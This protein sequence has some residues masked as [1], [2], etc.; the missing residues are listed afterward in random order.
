MILSVLWWFVPQ[1]ALTRQEKFGGL[2]FT[3]AVFV[4]CHYET[5]WL[6][7]QFTLSILSSPEHLL[8]VINTVVQEDCK[9]AKQC[10]Q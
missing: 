9:E 6:A 1:I 10:D 7:P 8:F 4:L 2:D 3:A 5:G